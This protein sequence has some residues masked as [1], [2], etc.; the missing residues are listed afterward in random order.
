[1]ELVKKLVQK[2]IVWI[3]L[4]GFVLRILYFRSG[5]TFT[6]SDEVY[7]F[8]NALKPLTFLLGYT[9]LE[10]VAELFRYFNFNWGWVTLLPSTLFSFFLIIFKIPI[11]EVT[12]NL[13]YVLLGT[14]TLY[15]IYKFVVLLKD[16]QTALV[17][18]LLFAIYPVHVSNS[19]SIGLVA[20]SA[21]FWFFV[22]LYFFLQAL[23]TNEVRLKKKYFLMF[24][25]ALGFYFATDFQFYG[26]IPILVILGLYETKSQKNMNI[27]Q[28]VRSLLQQCI[29]KTTLFFLLPV[30]P[31]VAAAGYLYT[32]DFFH[33]AYIAHIFQ[34]SG[35]G[36][37]FLKETIV[38]MYRNAGPAL[39]L[40]FSLCIM[41][42]IVWI[43]KKEKMASNVEKIL[44]CWIGLQMIPWVFL[45]NRADT[46]VYAYLMHLTS[47]L[48]LLAA[49]CMS[50]LFTRVQTKVV[51]GVAAAFMCLLIIIPTLFVV[52]EVV[53]RK[54]PL[55]SQ[56]TAMPT[57]NIKGIFIPVVS[58]RGTILHGHFGM[59]GENTGIKTIGYYI[60]E[61]TVP[62]ATIF[63]DQESF[64]TAYYTKRN[65]QG[66]LDHFKEEELM[67]D[68]NLLGNVDYVY[69]RNKK[70][71]LLA[72]KVTSDGFSEAIIVTQRR[73]QIGTL[74]Q[75]DPKEVITL[76]VEDVDPL[77]DKKYG[78]LA[79][80]FVDYS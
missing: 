63:T 3:I 38:E 79:V 69:L 16:E 32:K 74:Y 71:P 66:T 6:S 46:L 21:T 64:I 52:A 10:Y 77:F 57:D 47:G 70:Y 33:N 53:Y 2:K 30:A 78:N 50:T 42:V 4:L 7:L 39:F 55:T 54:N 49:C 59:R 20:I 41:L 75:K 26:I 23:R 44:L 61:H 1:M 12:I 67:K 56:D 51:K 34:K 35:Y 31:I 68:Y 28:A 22:V 19:R 8:Q 17:A 18:A 40:L 62:N 72:K 37:F 48:L 14:A 45:V 25:L 43:Y 60:R 58:L 24:F 36:G 27:I 65:V 76:A 15:L 5:E 80:L 11:T 9:P 29:N 73:I 13:P